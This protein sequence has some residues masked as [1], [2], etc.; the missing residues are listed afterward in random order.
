M[1]DKKITPF[2]F[3]KNALLVAP[4]WYL[5][6]EK[7]ICRGNSVPKTLVVHFF[8]LFIYASYLHSTLAEDIKDAKHVKLSKM[9]I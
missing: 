9:M 2:F 1:N 4:Y 8:I 6:A 7:V 5:R 3:A